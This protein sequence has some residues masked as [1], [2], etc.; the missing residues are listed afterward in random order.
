MKF[1]QLLSVV[2]IAVLVGVGSNI[3]Y[4]YLTTER[5]NADQVKFKEFLDSNWEDGLE[6]SPVFATLLGDNRYDDKVSSNSKE[7]YESGKEYDEYVLDTLNDIDIN[8]LS[9]D[10]QLNYWLLYLEFEVRLV[11]R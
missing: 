7:E 5:P 2:I 10:D 8:T 6:S 9:A 3:G 11:G 1:G 4:T